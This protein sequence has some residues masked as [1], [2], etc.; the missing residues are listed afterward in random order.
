M[1]VKSWT[2]FWLAQFLVFIAFALVYNVCRLQEIELKNV[3]ENRD[4]YSCLYA[5]ELSKRLMKTPDGICTCPY[6]EIPE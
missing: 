3:S 6:G 1:S 4:K 2:F 5:C